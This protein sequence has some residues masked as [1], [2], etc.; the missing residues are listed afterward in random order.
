MNERAIAARLVPMLLAEQHPATL[1]AEQRD[2]CWREGRLDVVVVNGSLSGYEIKSRRDSLARLPRQ[3]ELYSRV[4]DFAT[5]VCASGHTAL[6][7]RLVPEWWGLWEVGEADDR[8]E[9]RPARQAE[10]NPDVRTHD[11]VRLLLHDELYA[12]LVYVRKFPG[13]SRLRQPEMAALLV[14]ETT[15]DELREIVRRRLGQR[16]SWRAAARRL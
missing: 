16:P 1:I 14:G 12:E 9:I 15:L 6:A 5:L 7:Q 2:I 8:I 4:L 3:A 13:V 10:A 11:L